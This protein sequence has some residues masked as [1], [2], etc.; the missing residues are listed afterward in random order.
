MQNIEEHYINASKMGCES[1]FEFFLYLNVIE[2]IKA[3]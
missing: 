3:L 1:A 2:S